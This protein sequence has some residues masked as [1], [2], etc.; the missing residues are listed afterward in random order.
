MDGM[1]G[2]PLEALLLST[3]GPGW[4]SLWRRI[5]YE[6]LGW[7]AFAAWSGSF[8]PQVILNYKRKSVVGLNFD[9]VIFNLTKHT[10]YLIFNASMFFSATVQ[11]QYRETYGRTALIPVS[12]SD[13][14]FS[15]HAVILTAFTALQILWLE[16]GGQRVSRVCLLI[17]GTVWL[18]AIVLLAIAI[19]SGSWLWLVSSFNTIQVIMT[20]IKYI[21]QAWFNFVRRSTLGWSIGNILLDIT[22]GLGALLQM[23]LQAWDQ[24]SSEIFFG[25]PGKLCLSL[26]TI[27]FDTLFIVQHYILYPEKLLSTGNGSSETEPFVDEAKKW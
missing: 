4:H 17:S 23:V 24:K 21:P 7:I 6:T 25:N 11:A 8:W 16:K 1:E 9:F 10:S 27:A 12:S 3:D 26:E 14:A 2:A 19:P 22:G 18:G 5:L 20:T 13:V 15:T